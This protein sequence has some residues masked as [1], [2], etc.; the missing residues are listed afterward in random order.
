MFTPIKR[1]DLVAAA[2]RFRGTPFVHQGRNRDGVDC[3]GLLL[4][5]GRAC[6]PEID[7][8]WRE[9]AL[10]EGRPLLKSGNPIDDPRYDITPNAAEMKLWLEYVA[11]RKNNLVPRPGDVLTFLLNQNP[12]YLGFATEVQGR[13]YVLA[14]FSTAR[15]VTERALTGHLRASLRGVYETRGIV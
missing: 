1:A 15:M 3:L 9:M 10:A 6:N 8:Y 13:L 14:A 4:A 2:R 12:A 5:A 7:A 11:V